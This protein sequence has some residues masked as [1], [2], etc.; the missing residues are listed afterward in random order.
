MED[1]PR[2]EDSEPEKISQAVDPTAEDAP[3]TELFEETASQVVE[4]IVK[5]EIVSPSRFSETNQR[6]RYQYKNSRFAEARQT[7]E[8]YMSEMSQSE[9]E[10]LNEASRVFL[11]YVIVLSKDLDLLGLSKANLELI[12]PTLE[13]ATK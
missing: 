1:S 3:Q 10:D 7:I 11:R 5:S 13:E 9:K 4:N 8:K 6:V 12:Q 2:I